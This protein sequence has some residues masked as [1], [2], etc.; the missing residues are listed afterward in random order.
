MKRLLIFGLIFALI[1][2][3]ISCVNKSP[4]TMSEEWMDRVA[5]IF[6]GGYPENWDADAEYDGIDV[7]I[8]LLD[9]NDT[10][11]YVRGVTMPVKIECYDGNADKILY[12]TTATFS[13]EA[14]KKG[15]IIHGQARWVKRIPFEDLPSNLTSGDLIGTITLPN[16]KQFSAKWA[17]PFRP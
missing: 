8:G 15:V 4:P 6:V 10:A 9:A 2:V 3:S 1:F 11:I 14:L 17:M 12:A 16:G 13:D 7:Y 5:S